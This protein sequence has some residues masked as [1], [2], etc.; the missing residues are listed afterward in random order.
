MKFFRKVLFL[1]L[2]VII[3][4]LVLNEYLPKE[5]QKEP[6]IPQSVVASKNISFAVI[7]DIHSDYQSLQKVLDKI[8]KDKMEF[9]IVVGDLTTIGAPRELE[10]VKEI[11]DQSG[12]VYY[13]TSGNHDLWSKTK[14]LDPFRE[15]FGKEYQA[16]QIDQVR[17]ILINNASSLD[18]DQLDWLDQQIAD[19]PRLYCLVFSH[20]PL[21]HPY[22][23]HIMGEGNSL[24]AIQAKILV[25]KLTDSKIQK[26]YAGHVH[27]FLDYEFE[28]LKTRTDGAVYTHK[29]QSPFRFL[30]VT[31][32]RP[33]YKLEEQEV[34]GE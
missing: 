10:K 33:D 32:S 4:V 15:V 13:V 21:N 34:W 18:Q 6:V 9:V 24:A 22:L 2:L 20:M 31:V 12:L 14:I 5:R 26:L 1:S 28:G 17:F 19:C 16:F 8:K 27:Y 11:L 29:N 3:A 7:S 23:E 25:K 30:E